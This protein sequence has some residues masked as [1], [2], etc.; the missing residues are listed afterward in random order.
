MNVALSPI[1]ILVSVTALTYIILYEPSKLNC[2]E[3]RVL[4]ISCYAS[5][6]IEQTWHVI[7]L[8]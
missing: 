7:S 6:G 4:Y 2:K 5:L 1:E 8:N 3:E